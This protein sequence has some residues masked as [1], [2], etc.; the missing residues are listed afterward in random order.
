MQE[1]EAFQLL[2]LA[3]ARDGRRVSR[4]QAMV[5]AS[6]LDGMTMQE[7][8]DA[9]TTHFRAST[10]WLLP[11]HLWQIVKRKRGEA[12]RIQVADGWLLAA[13]EEDPNLDERRWWWK[14]SRRHDVSVAVREYA[15]RKAEGG[16][17]VHR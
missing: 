9:M 12:A 2:T 7:A 4:E 5:W 10:E 6:D 15:A 11:A 13:R 8:V 1:Q 14:L 3:S 17:E 16:V